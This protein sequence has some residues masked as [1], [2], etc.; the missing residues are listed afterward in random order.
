MMIKSVLVMLSLVM[1]F[2]GC[3]GL[4]VKHSSR[5]N[6]LNSSGKYLVFPFRDPSYKDK[7]FPGVGARF[8]RSFTSQCSLNGLN[9]VDVSN[10]QFSSIKDID[11]ASALTY[12]EQQGADFIITGQLT[13]WIDRATE[14][15]GKRDFAGLEI[16]VI[17]VKTKNVVFTA[18]ILEHSNVFWSGTPDDFITSL[19]KAMADEFMQKGGH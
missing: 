3:A 5:N 9:V 15:S 4:Q 14:W 18:E 8:T 1:M 12:G 16:A 10:G 19:S 11:L 7:Q 13:R 6:P 17:D 2:S